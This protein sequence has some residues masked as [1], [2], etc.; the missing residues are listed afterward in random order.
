MVKFLVFLN[1]EGRIARIS[2]CNPEKLMQE[3]GFLPDLF[4]E[5]SRPSI[6]SMVE[7]I[8]KNGS[9]SS[10]VT[11][12]CVEGRFIPIT[13]FGLTLEGQVIVLGFDSGASEFELCKNY[14]TIYNEFVNKVREVFSSAIKEREQSIRQQFEEIQ[15]LN[16]ELI[17]T[18]RKLEK[19]NVQLDR[20]NKDLQS[21]LVKDALTGVV[22]RHQYWEEMERA[23]TENPG[24][25][26][27]FTFLDIDDFKFINDTYGHSA[28]DVFLVQFARRLQS[29]QLPNTIIIRIAGDEFALFTYGTEQVDHAFMDN[30]WTSIRRHVLSDPIELFDFSVPVSI[31]AGMAVYGR[32]TWEINE[33]IELAD[34]AMYQAKSRG[35]G[36]YYVFDKTEYLYHKMPDTRLH[37]LRKIVEE[38]D[39][40]H[41]YQP[42]AASGDGSVFAYAVSMRTH[43]KIF[44]DTKDLLQAALEKGRYTELNRVSLNILKNIF[45]KMEKTGKKLFI[46]QGPYPMYRNEF[47]E[48]IKDEALFSKLILDITESSKAAQEEL[49]R[50]SDYAKESGCG[51]AVSSFGTGYAN[52]LMVLTAGP[53]YIKID[54]ELVRDIHMDKGRQKLLKNIV[55]FAHLKSIKVVAEG[56]EKREEMETLVSLNI[57]Y[58][59]GYYIGEP[60]VEPGPIKTCVRDE[61]IGVG[62]YEDN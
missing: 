41:V 29:M 42:V 18:R 10:V 4:V 22:S 12:V 27:V 25:Y 9:D 33:L 26:G 58:L 50:M 11:M 51:L 6:L 62:R 21:R 34:F 23:I 55:E 53:D 59:Q 38:Q 54:M 7:N 49:V 5:E 28:G 31:S 47:M 13:L 14:I 1:E 3:G 60:E 32:D 52:D 48:E 15:K 40:Y 61:I 39:L 44:R 46:T 45:P 24:K 56:I 8:T 2:W 37:E 30:I 36:Q 19:A 20:S 17:N 57:D 35:K 43:N 16:N